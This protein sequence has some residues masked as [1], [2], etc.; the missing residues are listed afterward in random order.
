MQEQH[1][2]DLTGELAKKLVDSPQPEGEAASPFPV[3]WRDGKQS[4]ELAGDRTEGR[5]TPSIFLPRL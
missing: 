1:I 2:E 4:I 5:E 3:E